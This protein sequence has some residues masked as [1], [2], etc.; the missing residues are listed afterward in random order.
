MELISV[1]VLNYNGKGFLNSCLSSLA[2]QTYSDFEVIVVDNGSRD[3]SPEYIEENY[4]WVR[5]AKNDENLGFAGGTNVGIRAA[6]GEFIITL[7]NDSRADSRF[8]EELIKPM[9]DPEVGVCAAKMLFPDGRINS[10]GICISRSGAAWDRGMFEP[11]RGQYEFV[12]E[13]FGACAGA[14][15]YRR[16][17]LD[18]IGLFDEDFF[19]YL[20]DVD[21]AF[22][23]RLAGWKCLYVP[24]AR[25]IHHHGGTAGVGSD[26]AVYYGNRNIVWYPIKDFPFRL[27]ITSLPFI[28]AR[29]LA[30]IPY[31]A[32]RGQGG[33]ILKSKLDAL[34]G[35]VKM[36]EKRK[37]V[38][39]RAD[40]SQINRFVEIWGGIKRQ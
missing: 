3:G 28:V 9:A 8:I 38:V 1:I 26:L 12:E 37:D 33:V 32:L 13:V 19:L 15:L 7:N 11:D 31:Y 27:L 5:L 14:A 39:R 34:K 16:E 10:A 21:L 18:E 2:S 35:V 36:M 22:R 24:G 25:V 40:Y 17:M 4:P 20:E 23:A 29:N 30:V 6:K